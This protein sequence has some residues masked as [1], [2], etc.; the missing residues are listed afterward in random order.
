[1]HNEKTLLSKSGFKLI[2]ADTYFI[3]QSPDGRKIRQRKEDIK[4]VKFKRIKPQGLTYSLTPQEK[5]IL[6]W[7]ATTEILLTLGEETIISTAKKD[8][9]DGYTIETLK[10]LYIKD[11]IDGQTII[12][13]LFPNLFS[14]IKKNNVAMEFEKDKRPVKIIDININ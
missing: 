11:I 14:E 9:R 8:G 12:E 5:G 10:K 13:A 6:M 7:C 3:Y 4:T 1:M 2:E